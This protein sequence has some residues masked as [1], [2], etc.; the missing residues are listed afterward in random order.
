MHT[1]AYISIP[2]MPLQN[3]STVVEYDSFQV[4]I[5]EHLGAVHDPVWLDDIDLS[6]VRR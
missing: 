5:P 6:L 4:V 1:V 3:G 2:D